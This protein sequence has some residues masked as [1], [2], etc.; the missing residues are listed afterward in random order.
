MI[1]IQM[2][3]TPKVSRKLKRFTEKMVPQLI[4]GINKAT[5]RLERAIKIEV[6]K[7]GSFR[8]R[9]GVPWL[10]NPGRHLRKGDGTLQSS[11]KSRPARRTSNN[12]EGAVSSNVI[13][14]A[15]HEFG[16]RRNPARPYVRPV[17]KREGNRVSDDIIN[18]IVKPLGGLA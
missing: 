7:G 3:M 16:H 1:D 15:A 14:S 12:V 13:Y 17:I 11:W 18:E 2:E 8:K 9:K 5:A 6:V 4:R 10:P